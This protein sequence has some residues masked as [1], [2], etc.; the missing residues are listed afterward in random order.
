MAE[1]R[2]TIGTLS[3]ALTVPDAA[4][5]EHLTAYYAA[6]DADPDATNE[7]KLRTI[8]QALGKHIV[9]TAATG[10]EGEEVSEALQ[11]A[12]TSTRTRVDALGAWTRAAS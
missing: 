10:I 2:L 3:E 12:R 8:V 7:E 4:A 9:D 6:L 1:L 11:T 5:L